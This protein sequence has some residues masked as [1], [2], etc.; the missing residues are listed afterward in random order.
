MAVLNLL[1]GDVIFDG[2]LETLANTFLGDSVKITCSK[3]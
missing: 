2:L 1:G 3:D